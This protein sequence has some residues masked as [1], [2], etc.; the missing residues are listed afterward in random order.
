ME[1]IWKDVVGYEG[2]YEVSNL[3]NVRSVDRV[4]TVERGKDT[5]P[6]PLKGKELKQTRQNHGYLGVWLYG[7]GGIAGRNGKMVA[8]HRIVADAFCRKKDGDCEVN[9][10]NED[11]SDNRACNLEWCTHAENSSYGTRGQR[12]SESNK[13]NPNKKRRR[14]AQYTLSGEFIQEFP[15][16]FALRQAGY[17]GGNAWECAN[18][19]PAYSHSEGY[20]WRFLN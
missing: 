17:N 2:L 16:I 15:S 7:R 10:L 13:R 18:G 6:Y 5:Y 9:H 14:I 8:V 12:I 3:G 1:E 4:I 19:N 11:K 20:I